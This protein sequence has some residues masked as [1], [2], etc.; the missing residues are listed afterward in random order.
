MAHAIARQKHFN[1]HDI[2]EA[3]YDLAR[4]NPRQLAKDVTKLAR[5][6]NQADGELD[7]ADS[8]T[9][10]LFGSLGALAVGVA[11]GEWEGH[12]EAT[13][14][15]M[16]ADWE[17]KGNSSTSDACPTPW[18]VGVPDPATILGPVP[19]LA[20]PPIAF[21]ILAGVIASGRYRASKGKK[22][23]PGG[24]EIFATQSALI[25]LAIMG[26]SMARTHGY[27]RRERQ[28]TT[29]KYVIDITPAEVAA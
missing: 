4:V 11:V 5:R 25:T 12:I 18:E 19:K 2:E 7:R 1:P 24:W 16:I 6:K 9:R 14:E 10:M 15:A 27:C 28:I 17:A 8:G 21:A 23:M 3:A 29:G 13:R 22:T 20:V 26:A